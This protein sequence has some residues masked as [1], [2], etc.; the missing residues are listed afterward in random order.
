MQK[1][2]YAIFFICSICFVYLFNINYVLA[3]D[4]KNTESETLSDNQALE[5]IQIVDEKQKHTGDY[6]AFCYIKEV[7]KN[8][9]PR[10]VQALV[11][12]RDTDN[13]FMILFTKPKED[14]GKGYLKIDKNLWNY[15]PTTRKWERRTEREKLA[16]T[17]SRRSDLDESKLGEEYNVKYDGSGVFGSYKIHKMKLTAKKDMDVAY[18]T[19]NLWIDKKDNNILKRAEI[20][21]SGKTV[22]TIFYPKWGKKY[23]E[24]KKALVWIPEEMRIFDELEK[25]NSTVISIENVELKALDSSIFTKAWIENKGK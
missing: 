4:T 15:D 20:A 7:E 17:N 10:V 6:K 9:D 16:N 2:R 19:L 14:V 23:S 11:Y 3:S 21:L 5:I 1:I 12:R 8:K 18:P 24:S 13:K 25:G 22:R